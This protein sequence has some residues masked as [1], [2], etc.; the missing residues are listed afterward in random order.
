M[1][2][3]LDEHAQLRLAERALADY[4]L[5]PN[6][7]SLSTHYRLPANLFELYAGQSAQPVLPSHFSSSS[8]EHLRISAK[9]EQIDTPAASVVGYEEILAKNRD[10]RGDPPSDKL[11][12]KTA[13]SLMD[14]IRWANLGWV[15][16]VGNRLSMC[17]RPA[18]R[19]VVVHQIVRLHPA[20][21]YSLSGRSCGHLHVPGPD[22]TLA[23]RLWNKSGRCRLGR[24]DQELWYANP[25]PLWPIASQLISS[26]PDTG[27]VNFY[28]LRDTLMGHVDRAEQVKKAGRL[29]PLTRA[30]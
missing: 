10:W 29:Y 16:Q 21:A 28:R 27:I 30:G 7:L 22:N 15:Y 11:G 23:R 9:R 13:L 26:V 20:T 12:A 5:A 1:P 19:M 17:R 8:T 14:D 25:E 3:Y 24:L 4:T 2:Q 6:P 18:E